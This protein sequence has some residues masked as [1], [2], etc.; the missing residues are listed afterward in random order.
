VKQINGVSSADAHQ[1]AGDL[2]A[3]LTVEGYLMTDLPPTHATADGKTAAKPTS[4]KATTLPPQLLLVETRLVKERRQAAGL[5]ADT[6]TPLVGL[7]LSGGGIRSA[8]FSLGIVQ[9]LAKARLLPRIDYLST[10]SGGGYIGSFIGALF[11]RTTLPPLPAANA[12]VDAH[13]LQPTPA[14]PAL[15]H[16]RHED[17]R[18]LWV[19]D[20]SAPLR[21]LRDNGRYLIPNGSSDAMMGFAI[22]MR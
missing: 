19:D 8:T 21:W 9:A 2:F 15:T 12:A 13:P 14:T 10:V 17:V 7:A 1:L 18:S 16:T 3:H 11:A 22:T 6:E 20:S 4:I 5:T